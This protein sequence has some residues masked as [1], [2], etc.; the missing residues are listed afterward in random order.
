[1]A[2]AVAGGLKREDSLREVGAGSVFV[3]RPLSP[4]SDVLLTSKRQPKRPRTTPAFS[5]IIQHQETPSTDRL[6]LAL[7]G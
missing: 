6:F 7:F 1:M 4:P 3:D 2:Q 5:T